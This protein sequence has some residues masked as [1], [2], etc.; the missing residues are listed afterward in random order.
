M[1]IHP[2]ARFSKARLVIA[3]IGCLML[4]GAGSAAADGRVN[5]LWVDNASGSSYEVTSPTAT[6]LSAVKKRV[7]AE[8][9]LVPGSAANYQVEKT[10][11]SEVTMPSRDPNGG[12]III[13]SIETSEVL[14]EGQ[15]LAALGIATGDTLK[16]VRKATSESELRR[17]R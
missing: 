11:V 9:G 7:M 16:L 8:I 13:G 17:G 5:L 3:G 15:T 6:T 4:F 1:K 14:D 12:V 10:V 2:L